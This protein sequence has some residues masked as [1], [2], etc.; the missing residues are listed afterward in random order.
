MPSCSTAARVCSATTVFTLAILLAALPLAVGAS[1]RLV[2]PV[3]A[4]AVAIAVR[5][6][7]IPHPGLQLALHGGI[8]LAAVLHLCCSVPGDSWLE[9]MYEPTTRTI[10]AYQQLGG[11]LASKIWIDAEGNVSAPGGAGLG[12]VLNEKM[13]ARYTV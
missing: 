1:L 10:E 3:I 13:I 4:V 11:V 9:L 2:P 8:G 5:A 12:V 7:A 6:P